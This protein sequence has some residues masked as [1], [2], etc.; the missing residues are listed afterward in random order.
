MID[1]LGAKLHAPAMN[2]PDGIRLQ[3]RMAQ[4]GIASRRESERMITAGR[5]M[6]DGKL[7]TELGTRVKKSARVLVDGQPVEGPKLSSGFLLNKP[8]GVICTRSDPQGRETVYDIL[9]PDLPYMGYVG[10]LDYNTEGVLL[11]LADGELAQSLLSPASKV[12]RVY[13]VKIRGRLSRVGRTQLEAGVP[14]DGQSTRPVIVE[15]LGQHQSKHD[16]LRLTLFE[17]KNRH[18]RRILEAVGHSVTKLRRASFG[19]ID[20]NEI[21][22][23]QG[24]PM[25]GSEI[26]QLRDLVTLTTARRREA[27]PKR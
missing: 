27:K 6:V 7:V 16:W 9:P 8:L 2:E 11:F 12:P 13:E 5:V 26:Q 1:P 15:R 14:L 4:L 22:L 21:L 20:A 10:R 25:E 24:R 23:G 19:G 18:V 3:K 17:G